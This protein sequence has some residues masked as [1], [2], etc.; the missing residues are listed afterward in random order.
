MFA[1]QLGIELNYEKCFVEVDSFTSSVKS[2]FDEGG[3]GLNVTVP[4]K[5]QAFQISN[6]LS[7]RAKVAGSVNTLKQHSDG[8]LFGD[9][10]DGLGFELDLVKNLKWSIDRK[11]VLLIGAGGAARGILM[12][13][14]SLNPNKIY[15]FNRTPERAELLVSKFTE[16]GN[17][18][19]NCFIIDK[20]IAYISDVSKIYRKDYKHFKNL[21]F[22]VIDCLWYNQHPSHFN[23]E[24]SLNMIKEFK[25]QKSIL[26]NLSPVLD[27]DELSK[28]LPKNII[29]AHDGLS[30][31]L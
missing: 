3:D 19:S 5:V 30:V 28:I 12:N 7:E 17:I 22:L 16:H 24:K 23:L 1:E 6:H 15:I 13:L 21:K 2:F 26:T 20:K 10:T 18:K 31:N 14:L 8:G 11:N 4:F 9:N 25:P 29:P 27:Y